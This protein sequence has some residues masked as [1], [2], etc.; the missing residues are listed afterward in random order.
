MSRCLQT[1]SVVLVLVLVLSGC[2]SLGTRTSSP[3]VTTRD[4]PCPEQVLPQCLS[5]PQKSRSDF[6]Y[7]TDLEEDWL[8]GQ[9]RWI[10]CQELIETFRG[11]Q[12]ECIRL[13][14]G[15]R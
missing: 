13:P 3:I 9:K 4:V 2:S 6:V 12:R 1:V 14:K 7:N 15:F 5:W 8:L 10:H 11:V